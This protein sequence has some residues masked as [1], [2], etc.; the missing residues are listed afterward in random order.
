M[1]RFLDEDFL[2]SNDTARELYHGAAEGLPIIDY[3]CHLSPREIAEDRRFD[4]VTQLMLGGDHYKWRA[5]LSDGV[6]EALI[7]GDGDDLEKFKAYARTVRRAIGN[8]LYH[9]THLELKRVFG[10][11]ETLNEDTAED[12][13]HRC[14]E[15]LRSPGFSAIGLID[16]FHVETLCTTDDPIDDLRY[17]AQIAKGPLKARVLPA[18][19]PD[20]ALKLDRADAAEYLMALSDVSGVVIR[21]TADVIDALTRRAEYFHARGARIADHGLDALPY[22]A[23]DEARADAALNAALRGETP[24]AGD[25]E[26][27]QTALLIALGGVYCRLGWA[28]QYHMSV[29]RNNNA[30]MFARFGADTGFD[31]IDDMPVARKLSR[32]LDAQDRAGALPPTVLYSLNPAANAVIGAML[33]NFQASGTRGK[34]QMGSAWWF[35]D[36]RDGM[37]AQM[38]TLANLGLLSDF[39]GMLTDSRSLISYPRHEYFRRILCNL[40]GSWVENG[41]YPAD[42]PF[43]KEMI[44]DIGY[45]NAKRYFGL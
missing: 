40:I 35:Q 28:Q 18:F 45:H 19:R 13:Y 3:H 5:M 22:A 11:G 20:R 15:L 6:E 42:L 24:D 23:P 43:L 36:Q 9:W 26:C 4:N 33:G 21:K 27:Y 39:I 44:G 41:E 31:S 12:I 29:I 7:R 2:L 16:R 1:R 38:K 25:L 34:I 32:L 10:V 37:E 17:H 14:N 8:P 30:R